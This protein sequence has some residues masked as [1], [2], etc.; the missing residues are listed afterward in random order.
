MVYTFLF[1]FIKKPISKNN[2][3]NHCFNLNIGN[4]K[5]DEKAWIIP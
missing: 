2:Y 4:T 1:N 3:T 5:T